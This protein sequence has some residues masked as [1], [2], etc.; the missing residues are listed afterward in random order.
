MA[1]TA[2]I[3]KITLS[4]ID[5]GA[6]EER[7]VVD[8]IRSKWLTMGARTAEF[9]QR[10]AEKCGAKHAVAV[11]NC[12]AALHLALAAAGVGPGDE[13]IVPTLTFVATANA[14]LYCGAIPVFADVTGPERLHIDPADAARKVT[15]RTKA[16]VP[17]HY[18]GYACDMAPL[19]D[20][21]AARGIR[22]VE[23]AAHAPGATWRGQAVGS[24]GD[25]T[26]F[27]FFSNK[28]LSTG[29]GG[30]ITTNDDEMAANLRLNRSHGMTTLTYDRH[31]GHAFSYDVI[32]AGYNYRLTELQSALG[33][34]QLAKLDRNN[35]VRRRLVAEYRRQLAGIEGV[36]VPFAGMDA[37]SSCHI[38]S[39][40]LPEGADRTA[41]QQAM[42]DEGIQTS[43]HYPPVHTFTNFQ[44]RFAADVPMV[45]RLAPRQL[46]LPLHPLM[47]IADVG[48]VVESLSRALARTP[49]AASP[50]V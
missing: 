4:D 6:D 35:G 27:S 44:R 9:E 2:G 32:S 1:T 26:C 3:W 37:E 45:D 22:L 12:T 28:N 18:A 40:L 17:V 34:V 50:R 11:N 38:L 47:S 16:I 25:L 48:T 7:T 8:V 33:L 5:F 24:I 31:R 39:V 36:V 30:M 46:T 21:A 41:V 23:D 42:K 10:F 19:L 14:A 29:E 43:I 15:A 13:V 20:L 49:A